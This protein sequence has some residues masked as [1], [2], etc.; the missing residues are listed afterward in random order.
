MVHELDE[1]MNSQLDASFELKE[2]LHLEF[3]R[4]LD[5]FC[6]IWLILT[7]KLRIY[8]SN[9]YTSLLSVLKR[10]KD[11]FSSEIGSSER[12]A[13]S[14][15]TSLSEWKQVF[16]SFMYNIQTKLGFETRSDLKYD[17]LSVE[18][19]HECTL[20]LGRNPVGLCSILKRC[21]CKFRRPKS[22]FDHKY[23]Y[24][25]GE[26]DYDVDMCKDCAL[27]KD[28]IHGPVALVS[29]FIVSNQTSDS[30]NKKSGKRAKIS[31]NTQVYSSFEN[32]NIYSDLE[33]PLS[34]FLDKLK[35]IT[36]SLNTSN[37]I[38][39][40]DTIFKL[41]DLIISN[42][43]DPSGVDKD[44]KLLVDILEDCI[45]K[46]RNI[47]KNENK[48]SDSGNMPNF[49]QTFLVGYEELFQN[50]I[51]LTPF[52]TLYWLVDKHLNNAVSSLEGSGAI[53]KLQNALD[54]TIT[55]YNCDRNIESK[56]LIQRV[57]K[58]N[59]F[60][61]SRRFQLVHP[62]LIELFYNLFFNMDLF[63]KGNLEPV[64]TKKYITLSPDVYV[65]I[66]DKMKPE[67][68][69]VL[70][71]LNT[72]RIYGIG[73]N[74]NFFRIKCLHG[75]L[76]FELAEGSYIGNLVARELLCMSYLLHR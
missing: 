8:N 15:S 54:T 68:T 64:D 34:R 12:D 41:V 69:K 4:Y 49:F 32:N 71:I 24:S 57:I 26:N 29:P 61:I 59:L 37:S 43:S 45:E 73:G 31:H 22:N 44:T 55:Q 20:T 62:T 28:K 30:S 40:G 39:I 16:K 9:S 74:K 19:Y 56:G 11:S 23:S 52:P 2:S 75:N 63:S 6:I 50:V 13:L 7:G 48:S 72:L 5:L 17:I 70:G 14:H 33:Y 67:V 76:S 58:D 36:L 65:D 47:D 35:P 60:Y 46:S 10:V 25:S 51:K 21:I 27:N 66:F 3:V 42:N 1:N 53:T 38:V 18:D